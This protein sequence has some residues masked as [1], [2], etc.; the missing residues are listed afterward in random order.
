MM[1]KKIFPLFLI[2]LTVSIVFVAFAH[3]VEDSLPKRFIAREIE[4]C[5]LEKFDGIELSTEEQ[6]KLWDVVVGK[7]Y[8]LTLAPDMEEGYTRITLPVDTESSDE[9]LY[10]PRAKILCNDPESIGIAKLDKDTWQ[11]EILPTSYIQ[12]AGIETGQY[13]V[14][15]SIT[16]VGIYAVIVKDPYDTVRIKEVDP[17][18][19]TCQRITCGSYKG[20]ETD[21]F[22]GNVQQGNPITLNFC[23]ILTGCEASEAKGTTGARACAQG[24]NSQNP[25]LCT[26]GEEPDCCLPVPDGKC[27]PD[28]WKVDPEGNI[29]A[30]SPEAGQVVKDS[31]DPDCIIGD[32]ELYPGNPEENAKPVDIFDKKRPSRDRWGDTPFVM[33]FD[34]PKLFEGEIIVEVTGGM[35]FFKNFSYTD[36]EGNEH[37]LFPLKPGVGFSGDSVY[38]RYTSPGQE[39]F[40]PVSAEPVYFPHLWAQRDKDNEID[41]N[42]RVQFDLPPTG[43]RKFSVY[44]VTSDVGEVSFTI[45]GYAYEGNADPDEDNSNNYDDCH[46][47]NPYIYPG[48]DEDCNFIDDNCNGY[49]IYN[50]SEEDD[51]FSPPGTPWVVGGECDWDGPPSNDDT[52]VRD[53]HYR[54][55]C[56]GFIEFVSA[57]QGA[58][59]E[60]W[61]NET[62]EN[63]PGPDCPHTI[64]KSISCDAA[65]M[66]GPWN[67]YSAIF[68]LGDDIDDDPGFGCCMDEDNSAEGCDDGG[69]IIGAHASCSVGA[70]PDIPKKSDGTLDYNSDTDYASNEGAT[71]DI[72]TCKGTSYL[73]PDDA[74]LGYSMLDGRGSG[75]IYDYIYDENLRLKEGEMVWARVIDWGD[76]TDNCGSI[77]F[78]VHCYK[79]ETNLQ[80]APGTLPAERKYVDENLIQCI[81]K[82]R[83]MDIYVCPAAKL[84][85]DIVF[86]DDLGE[87]RCN[88]EPLCPTE[89]GVE[90]GNKS[91][92]HDIAADE[93]PG[94]KEFEVW[95]CPEGAA[96]FNFYKGNYNVCLAKEECSGVVNPSLN[97]DLD[98]DGL[99]P[100]TPITNEAGEITGI[101][102]T[103]LL[104]PDCMNVSI[105]GD[106]D[107][108]N[109]KWY[110]NETVGYIEDGYCQVCGDRDSFCTKVCE[111]GQ[112]SC[113]GG[114]LQD[115]C[116]IAADKWCN[117]GAW[118]GSIESGYCS[119]CGTLDRECDSVTCASAACDVEYNK[120][121]YSSNWRDTR[122]GVSYCEVPACKAKDASCAAAC[123]AGACDTYL[124]AYCRTAG[125]WSANNAADYCAECGAVDADCGT[126]ACADGHCDIAAK[127]VCDGGIWKDSMTDY[128]NKC[129]IL[130]EGS[131][132]ATCPPLPWA[133]TETNCTDGIDNDCSG[134][135]DCMDDVCK[136]L[137]VCA[138]ACTP[139][140][141]STGCGNNQGICSPGTHTCNMDGRWG[142]CVGGR[143]PETEICNGFDD[144]CDGAVDEGCQCT[145]GQSQICG[146]DTGSCRSGTQTCSAEGKWG[147]CYRSSRS[148]PTTE[149]CD[150]YDND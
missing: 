9:D 109:K 8:E 43:I 84:A 28:C 100:Y 125:T 7:A 1:L 116:D 103:K 18:G 106:C 107:F 137:D 81:S 72:R 83:K 136:A 73:G 119:K 69:C 85:D 78:K 122:G 23:N 104:D 12:E 58:Y 86:I 108:T 126:G 141:F 149:V 87:R 102:R 127:K 42:P 53:Y 35:I 80:D 89:F 22:T 118:T 10:I 46:D 82:T 38:G 120:T 37:L 94:A 124:N 67:K 62:C 6:C 63:C 61:Q 60:V 99:T 57:G 11:W 117:A 55:P 92:L 150:G 148:S 98:C 79:Q 14:D 74:S 20:F 143:V 65:G 135:A 128:C 34:K 121:C 93:N 71:Y 16:S 24:I 66:N 97:F 56:D 44:A 113:D 123:E 47:N 88:Q 77:N 146:Q 96:C 147:Y 144:N 21:P 33:P 105:V 91:C 36:L 111:E 140:G 115:T 25:A 64:G 132:M 75:Y 13:K 52:S 101:D 112:K 45:K 5:R 19:H 29:I 27:D 134:E 51:V 95:V 130:D 133:D 54:M 48:A 15:A 26:N 50:S 17:T 138:N 40:M 110:K 142:E 131:C 39:E 41:G 145:A 2:L 70:M 76:Y 129:I 114:C 90:T 4:H 68:A 30:G 32:A 31:T 3:A 139:Y 49:R 59:L